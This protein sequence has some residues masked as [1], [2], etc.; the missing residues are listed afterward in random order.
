[1]KKSYNFQYIQN[2][3]L[4]MQIHQ[5]SENIFSK[6]YPESGRIPIPISSI[7]A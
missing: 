6:Q 2:L 4:E 1:M 5:N 7:L 3:L